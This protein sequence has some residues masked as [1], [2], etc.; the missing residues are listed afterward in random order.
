[1]GE[2]RMIV[3]FEGYRIPCIIGIK[4]YERHVE[5]DIFIDIKVQVSA[6]AMA[7][8]DDIRQ[9]IDYVQLAELCKEIAINGRYGLIETYAERVIEK[10]FAVFPVTWAWIRVN[11]PS[12]LSDARCAFVEF[13]NYITKK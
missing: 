10:I 12:A 2:K 9:T 3:G 8:F 11:K 4:P 1:M 7:G 13:E 5:Q 6:D